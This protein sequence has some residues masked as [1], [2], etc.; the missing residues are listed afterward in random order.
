MKA[1]ALTMRSV[2]GTRNL[3]NLFSLSSAILVQIQNCTSA[4][5]AIQRWKKWKK[6][7]IRQ[8]K[9][10]I[11]EWKE[12]RTNSKKYTNSVKFPTTLILA[13][14][15][16]LFAHFRW[17]WM[18]YGYRWLYLC[19]QFDFMYSHLPQRGRRL[20]LWLLSR[21][22]KGSGWPHLQGSV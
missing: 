5:S 21:I 4:D 8:R 13:N 6:K 18:C 7:R 3:S 2:T 1:R 9:K 17:R 11:R 16:V 22:L 15:V 14:S 19:C 20:H 10:C 12:R